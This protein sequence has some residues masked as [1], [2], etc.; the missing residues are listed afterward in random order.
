MGA[1]NLE[2]C[3]LPTRHLMER[4]QFGRQ[5]LLGGGSRERP[6]RHRCSHPIHRHFQ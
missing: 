5:P 2:H 6:G 4:Q 1:I 3:V